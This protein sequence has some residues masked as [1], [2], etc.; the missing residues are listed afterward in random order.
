MIK[1]VRTSDALIITSGLNLGIIKAVGDALEEGEIY[2]CDGGLDSRFKKTK[3]IGI[4]PWGYVLHRE[5]LVNVS[6]HHWPLTITFLKP[7]FLSNF[8]E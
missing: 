2:H 3:C 4:A 6:Q 5:K 7:F 1:A 8:T